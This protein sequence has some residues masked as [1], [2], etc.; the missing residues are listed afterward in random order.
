MLFMYIDDKLSDTHH[1]SDSMWLVLMVLYA[2]VL[3][4]WDCL[5]SIERHSLFPLSSD[6][7]KACEQF[8]FVWDEL[9]SPKYSC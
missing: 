5:F 6:S 3:H 7:Y 4:F 9:F 8:E 2:I 1:N